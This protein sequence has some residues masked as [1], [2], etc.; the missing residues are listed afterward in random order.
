MVVT[1]W[2]CSQSTQQHLPTNTGCYHILTRHGHAVVWVR[3]CV[4]VVVV[5]DGDV[6]CCRPPSMSATLMGPLKLYKLIEMKT[7][8]DWN[9]E[10]VTTHCKAIHQWQISFVYEAPH[11]CSVSLF[12]L[13]IEKT[14][15]LYNKVRASIRNTYHVIRATWCQ[16]WGYLLKSLLHN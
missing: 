13:T 9:W 16:C 4:V 15:C 6:V 12:Y 2:V 7:W 10:K 11:L 3:V 5:V 1:L 8:V 14:D